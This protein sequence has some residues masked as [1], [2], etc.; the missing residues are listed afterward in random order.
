MRNRRSRK[1]VERAYVEAER[2]ALSRSTLPRSEL[3]KALKYLSNQRDPLSVFLRDPK[4]PIHNNDCE[5]TLRHIVIGR[6]NWLVFGSPKG[7]KVACDFYS[8]MLSCRAIGLNPEAYLTD[9]LS[10]IGTTP[11]NEIASLTPWA[12]AEAHPQAITGPVPR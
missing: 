2:L 12:W 10:K 6:K 3:G 1:L 4:V 9:A 7:G 11:A 8:L 5:R